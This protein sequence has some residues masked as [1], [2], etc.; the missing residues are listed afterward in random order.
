[1]ISVKIGVTKLHTI[2]FNVQKISKSKKVRNKG[3]THV[4]F[5][6]IRPKES[7]FRFAIFSVKPKYN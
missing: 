7:S 5:D 3:G 2:F 1:M 6:L 4:V